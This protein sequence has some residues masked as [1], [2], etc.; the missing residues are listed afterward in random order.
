MRI[1]SI[2]KYDTSEEKVK[3]F[4]EETKDLNPYH[5][6]NRVMPGMFALNI[7][8]EYILKPIRSPEVP[9]RSLEIKFLNKTLFPAQLEL[10]ITE[11]DDKMNFSF[12][13]R[14]NSNL[15]ELYNG[16][17]SFTKDSRISNESKLTAVY[18]IPGELQRKFQGTAHFIEGDIGVYFYQ[19]MEFNDG[20]E[21]LGELNFGQK[22]QIEKRICEVEA[23]YQ[24]N[25]IVSAR[26]MTRAKII[27]KKLAER[28]AKNFKEKAKSNV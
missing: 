26:G 2:T 13:K 9:I 8:A 7:V 15:T 3:R 20:I 1:I 23:Y 5:W 17:I 11:S 6:E 19:S 10:A 16:I 28:F 18:N 14:E 4:L 27:G 24:N 22:N 12:F 25:E 21:K